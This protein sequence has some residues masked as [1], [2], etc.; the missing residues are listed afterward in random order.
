MKTTTPL[1]AQERVILFCTATAVSHAAVGITAHAMQSM[2]IKG[3]IVHDRE[4]GAYALTDS[5]RAAAPPKKVGTISTRAPRLAASKKHARG[6]VA[7]LA[8]AGGR[9]FFVDRRG[10][11]RVGSAGPGACLG[12]N[13]SPKKGQISRVARQRKGGTTRHLCGRTVNP[14]V[15]AC[16]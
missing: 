4:S 2:A 14:T 1:T 5:G 6:S 10:R 11:L 16:D 3:F 13:L 12:H 9:I 15:A 7:E 8:A